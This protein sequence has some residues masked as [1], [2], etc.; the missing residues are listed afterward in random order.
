MA[1][2]KRIKIKPS[3]L[4]MITIALMFTLI[5]PNNLSN[6]WFNVIN[7]ALI[8]TLC[9]Y[10]ASVLMGMG[11]QAC[12]ATVTFMGLGAYTAANLC[13]GRLGIQTSTL[14]SLVIA[15]IIVGI[16]GFLLGLVL[17]RLRKIFFVFGTIGLVQIGYIFFHNNISLFGGL[18]GIFGVPTLEVGSFVFDSNQKWFYL[19]MALVVIGYIVVERIRRTKMGR[20]LASIRDNETAALSMG[21]NVHMTKVYA[22]TF[23]AMMGGLAGALYAMQYGSIWADLYNGAMGSKFIIMLV[24]GG[25]NHTI[26][27]VIGAVVISLLPEIFRSLQSFLMFV[28]G[29]AIILMMVFLPGGIASIG[30]KI[31]LLFRKLLKNNLPNKFIKKKENSNAGKEVVADATDSDN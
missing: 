28:Y 21:V 22:M 16:I 11:G 14:A 18:N 8:Y 17:F 29:L 26:G 27:A 20:S 9:V 24:M 15:P 1:T 23:M 6:Y 7:V 2:I 3:G 19:L 13:M 25:M 10:G 31:K 30:D 12:F 5:A 4:L